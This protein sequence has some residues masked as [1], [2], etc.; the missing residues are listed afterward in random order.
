MHEIPSAI[1]NPR[2]IDKQN[3]QPMG[4]LEPTNSTGPYA[5]LW[6]VSPPPLPQSINGVNANL[7][8]VPTF[9]GVVQAVYQSA[10]V[11]V[12][13]ARTINML[14]E[15]YMIID[16]YYFNRITRRALGGGNMTIQ[17]F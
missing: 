13:P 3:G 4:D 5:L 14:N 6:Q 8:A 2:A 17:C 1:H 10:S 9:E 11:A 15:E 7:L 12:S 16:Q